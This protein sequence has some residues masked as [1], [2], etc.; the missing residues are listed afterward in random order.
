MEAFFN[1]EGFNVVR[2]KNPNKKEMCRFIKDKLRSV[3]KG[4]NVVFY[5]TGH[6]GNKYERGSNG[7]YKAVTQGLVCSD[8][9]WLYSKELTSFFDKVVKRGANVFVIIDACASGEMIDLDFRLHKSGSL[10][11]E[12]YDNASA[13]EKDDGMLL[14]LSGCKSEEISKTNGD[15]GYLTQAF[16]RYF[17]GNIS[18]KKFYRKTLQFVSGKKHKKKKGIPVRLLGLSG[19]HSKY[20]VLEGLYDSQLF[21]EE[22]WRVCLENQD[23]I[24]VTQNQ[25]ELLHS[26][27]QLLSNRELDLNQSLKKVLGW[28]SKRSRQHP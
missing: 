22:T 7:E 4:E 16:L 15:G 2:K 21:G 5:Y 26:H 11:E 9:E 12:N 19:R 27:P 24:D 17:S 20:A 1:R 25:F 14:Y 28:G 6:G 8:D 3:K 13:I 18:L 23:K 10:W